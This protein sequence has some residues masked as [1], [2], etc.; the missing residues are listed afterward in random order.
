MENYFQYHARGVKGLHL[1]TS[2]LH[3]TALP[4]TASLVF[5]FSKSKHRTER[6][7]TSLIYV[8]TLSNTASAS[9]RF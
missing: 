8:K 2:S 3:A 1:S 5:S 9:A 4:F 7:I 6:A